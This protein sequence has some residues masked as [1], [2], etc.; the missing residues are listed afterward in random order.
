MMTHSDNVQRK[1]VIGYLQVIDSSLTEL[2]TVHTVLKRSM[3]IADNIG[4]KDVV[5]VFD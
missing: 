1:D 5:I 2:S 3:L 4:Q